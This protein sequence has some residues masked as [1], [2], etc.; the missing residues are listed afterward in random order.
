MTG[1]A[2]SY[3][4]VRNFAYINREIDVYGKMGAFNITGTKRVYSYY[5]S[6]LTLFA[7]VP[8]FVGIVLIPFL[9]NMLGAGASFILGSFVK[10]LLSAKPSE[11]KLLKEPILEFMTGMPEPQASDGN[12]F[13]YY[14]LAAAVVIIILALIIIFRKKIINAIKNLMAKIAPEVPGSDM[15]I[16]EEVITKAAKE[17]KPK[18]SYKDYFKKAKKIKDLREAFLFSYRY[19]FWGTIKKDSELKQSV[20]PF[21]L[22]QKY[23]DTKNPGDLYCDIVYGQKPAENREMLIEMLTSAESFLREF[24]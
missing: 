8:V 19:I 10:A 2:V 11:S 7:V 3:F 20:T 24:L 14:I 18:L 22:A 1:F 17:K 15:V 16:N 4:I 9:I 12:M 13:A 23:S 5:F 21:E 6:T